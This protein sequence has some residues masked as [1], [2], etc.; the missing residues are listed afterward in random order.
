MA[1]EIL[2]K[3]CEKF[4]LITNKNLKQQIIDQFFDDHQLTTLLK[5]N[6]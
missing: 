3:L 1:I 5:V 4:Y 2:A 6:L